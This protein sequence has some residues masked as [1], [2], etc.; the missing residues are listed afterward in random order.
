MIL[1]HTLILVKVKF[2]NLELTLN[3]YLGIFLI[4]I[5]LVV[6]IDFKFIIQKNLQ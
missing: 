3:S 1:F 5:G 4:L 6:R 2:I